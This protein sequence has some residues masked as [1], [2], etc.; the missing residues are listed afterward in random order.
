M[1]VYVS[2]AEFT[3]LVYTE[4]KVTLPG[5][6]CPVHTSLRELYGGERR[7]YVCGLSFIY[8]DRPEFTSL[9][10][11]EFTVTLPGLW[12]PVHTRLR[13]LYGGARR[14]YVCGLSFIYVD[15]PEFTSLVISSLRLWFI[16]SLR[17][18]AVRLRC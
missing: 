12:R 8:S 11:I 3:S 7:V 18:R 13:E 10:Y 2:R 1:L 4:F 17:Q 14:V 6:W 15:R 16:S 5:L 9:V